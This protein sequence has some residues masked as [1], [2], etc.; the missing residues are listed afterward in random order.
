MHIDTRP[1]SSIQKFIK[2][3][4]IEQSL[5]A[6]ALLRHSNVRVIGGAMWMCVPISVPIRITN[7]FECQNQKDFMI[8]T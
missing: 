3:A 4:A 8:Y 5:Q 6:I 1:P 2:S 7:T